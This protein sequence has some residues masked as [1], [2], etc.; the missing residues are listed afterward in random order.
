[1]KGWTTGRETLRGPKMA[2][3]QRG[4]YEKNRHFVNDKG[5]IFDAPAW[6]AGL[7]GS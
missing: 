7:S 5:P 2:R 3:E 4:S 1:M 6:P